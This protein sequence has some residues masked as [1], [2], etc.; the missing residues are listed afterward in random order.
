MLA[1]GIKCTCVALP[2]Y[3]GA[4]ANLRDMTLAPFRKWNSFNNFRKDMKSGTDWVDSLLD[5]LQALYMYNIFHN[6]LIHKLLNNIW[7]SLGMIIF[8]CG[9][10]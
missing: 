2:M 7:A 9:S 5:T 8:S 1:Y 3:L 4:W 10:K 6:S